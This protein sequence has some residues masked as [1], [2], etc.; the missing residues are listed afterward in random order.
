MNFV[1]FVV[2][3][4]CVTNSINFR[5][6]GAMSF[7][8]DFH[9]H[10]THSD[11]SDTPSRVAERAAEAGLD[12]IALTDHDT[13]SGVPEAADAAA[14][15]GI[16]F[17]NGVEVSAEWGAHEVHV[18]GLGVRLE[19][20]DLHA[21]L[22]RQAAVRLERGRQMVEKLNGLGV[23]VSWEKVAARAEAGVVGRMHVALEVLE[24][25][26]ASSVQNA[27]NKYIKAGKPAYVPK[28][29]LSVA[30]S[31]DLI[32]DAKG[33]AFWAH[34]ALGGLPK[35]FEELAK[36]PFDGIEVYHSRHDAGHAQYLLD[37]AREKGL[38]VTGGSDCHGTVKGHAPLMG[39]VRL[40]AEH[41]DAIRSALAAL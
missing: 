2:N 40:G 25:G 7:G 18:L 8:A 38:L 20:N 15:Y 35:H 16:E 34:P 39:R 6:N 33:L 9:L 21:A 37:Y 23:P 17:L 11:G 22:D 30:E 31:I 26:H 10:S 41:Y 28:L 24:I 13:T 27:F 19:A 3:K 36:Q 1:F 14:Q 4:S 12:A 32:H 29:R 5:Y